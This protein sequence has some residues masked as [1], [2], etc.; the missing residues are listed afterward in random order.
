LKGFVLPT[1]ENNS[2]LKW[3][4]TLPVIDNIQ[5]P[6]ARRLV[7]DEQEGMWKEAAVV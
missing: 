4:T 7:A 1:V 3:L 6:M 2:L 5:R